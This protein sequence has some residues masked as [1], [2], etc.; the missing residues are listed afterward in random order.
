MGQLSSS[1]ENG[2]AG[3]PLLRVKGRSCQVMDL[4]RKIMAM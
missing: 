3:V 2:A 1:I 4:W